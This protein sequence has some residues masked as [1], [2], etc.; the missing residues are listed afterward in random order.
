MER[1]AERETILHLALSRGKRPDPPRYFSWKWTQVERASALI[2]GIG[3]R[4]APRRDDG[5]VARSLVQ[6]TAD[7]RAYRLIC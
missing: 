1:D 5:H 6:M 2:R 7:L 3:G 4:G